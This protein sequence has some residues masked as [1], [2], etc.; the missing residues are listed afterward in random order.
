MLKE[1]L[2][3]SRW[4]FRTDFQDDFPKDSLVSARFNI[5]ELVRIFLI[6]LSA[7]VGEVCFV[8]LFY[9]PSVLAVFAKADYLYFCS[10]N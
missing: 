9:R 5:S 7:A 2:I 8:L 1:L 3:G 4:S 10:I 6:G